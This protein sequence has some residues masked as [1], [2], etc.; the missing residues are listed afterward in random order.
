MP[1][2]IICPIGCGTLAMGAAA[3]AYHAGKENRRRREQRREFYRQLQEDI[4]ETHAVS[5][6]GVDA[7]RQS[8][9]Q[10]L[11]HTRDQLPTLWFGSYKHIGL[12]ISMLCA[13]TMTAY[14]FE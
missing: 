12:L 4:N 1:P 14:S 3:Y 7:N 8:D 13:T 6:R 9:A 5:V 10:S 2:L 11:T